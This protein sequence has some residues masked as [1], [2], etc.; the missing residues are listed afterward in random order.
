MYLC[1]GRLLGSGKKV[2]AVTVGISVEA[3][4]LGYTDGSAMCLVTELLSTWVMID[5]F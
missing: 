2:F 5:V 4:P 3:V 1:P